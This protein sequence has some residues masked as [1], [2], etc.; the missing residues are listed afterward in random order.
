[1]GI[2]EGVGWNEHWV[3]HATDESLNST[4][5]TNLKTTECHHWWAEGGSKLVAILA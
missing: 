5:E 2:E 1:M 4:S 3:L